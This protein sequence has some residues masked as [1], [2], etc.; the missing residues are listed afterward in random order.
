MDERKIREAI[1]VVKSAWQLTPGRGHG[2][3]MGGHGG[4]WGAMGGH[5]GPWGAMGG[6]GGP[7][8]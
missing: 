7:W 8:G 2:G 5:G 4:P 1:L 3:A 6:H